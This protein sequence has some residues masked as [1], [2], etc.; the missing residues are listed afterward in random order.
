M[1]S[2]SVTCNL[3]K[4]LS[5][6]PGAENN[7]S[8]SKVTAGHSRETVPPL[9]KEREGDRG[10]AGAENLSAQVLLQPT[11]CLSKNIEVTQPCGQILDYFLF[12]IFI[13]H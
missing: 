5:S 3:S 10:R 8:I 6:W 11:V 13:K 4:C 12:C 7:T 1:C 9:W 2:N